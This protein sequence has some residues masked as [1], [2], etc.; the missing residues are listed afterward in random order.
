MTKELSRDGFLMLYN[1]ALANAGELLEESELLFEAGWLTIDADKRKLQDD[2]G[3]W[4][5]PKFK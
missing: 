4:S 1:R 5:C 2:A 3:G